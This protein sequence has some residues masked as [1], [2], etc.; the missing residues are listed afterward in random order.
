MRAA[1]T[2]AP[3]ASIH[4]ARLEEIVRASGVFGEEEVAV[5][6]ELFDET[7]EE[8]AVSADRGAPAESSSL[9]PPPS[10]LSSYHFLGAFDSDD[11]LVGYACY[12]ATPGTEGTW[13][14]YWIA[15]HPEAQGSGVGTILMSE[16]E[17]RLEG[18]SARMLVVETS[19]RSD[20]APTRGFYG[21]RGYGEAA[22]V[23]EFYAPGDDRI[24]LTKRFHSPTVGGEQ[25][26][27]E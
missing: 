16:V 26:H 1:I 7:F 27:H 23:R 5:A 18:L 12:G 8:R 20:Y 11:T 14:L 13:D 3:L 2:L 25:R 24:I 4:R 21:R 15:V 17:R 6:L 9:L 19:S 10:S 22:R